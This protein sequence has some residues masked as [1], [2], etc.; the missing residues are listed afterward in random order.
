[1][2]D[3]KKI[4]YLHSLIDRIGQLAGEMW[5]LRN[6]YPTDRYDISVVTFPPDFKPGVN[7]AAY[8]MVF[9]DLRVVHSTDV[10]MV[11][12]TQR[13]KSAPVTEMDGYIMGLNDDIL[14][15]QFLLQYKKRPQIDYYFSLSPEQVQAGE[16]LREKFKIPPGAPVVTLHVR[17]PG[18]LPELSYH[19]F[20]DASMQNYL[21]LLQY[22]L[23]AGYWVVRLG[24]KTM[25]R[26]EN[27]PTNLIDAPFH[28]DYCDLVD[29]YFISISR[30]YIGTH[31][32]PCSVARGLNIPVVYLN[33]PIS[34][35]Y[36]GMAR[37]IIAPKK[38]YSLSLGRFLTYREIVNSDLIDRFRTENFKEAGVEL[39]EN[40]AEEILGAVQEM[41]SRLDGSYATPTQL[42]EF[43]RPLR[44]IDEQAEKSWVTRKP[45]EPL[46]FAC[47]RSSLSIEFL[48]HNPDFLK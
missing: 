48:K 20:R 15:R 38:Y 44:A 34:W 28:P 12:S 36:F 47:T 25:Q 11:C 21:P 4:L 23:E 45:G 2:P 46:A 31:S 7:K 10:N 13:D 39:R 1:M 5:F 16:V 37:D 14:L 24:D 22:L 26:F 32:G 3:R 6:V 40:S 43:Y 42:E 19:S 30:F 8:E 9:R 27:P 29:P 35:V 18:F 17:E 41:E 33:S